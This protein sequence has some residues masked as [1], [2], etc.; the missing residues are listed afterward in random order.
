MS[1]RLCLASCFLPLDE[2][3]CRWWLR[4]R[5]ELRRHGHDLVLISAQAPALADLPVVQVPLWLHGYAAAY[6]VPE[7]PITLEEPLAQALA[8][9]DRH[10]SG[11][12]NL[13]LAPFLKGVATAQHVLRTLLNELQPALVLAWGSSLPQSVILQQLALQ[14][15][16]PCWVIERGFFPD[17]LMLEMTGHGGHSELNWSFT[18]RHATATA[19]APKVLAATR[20]SFRPVPVPA[21]DITALHK[22]YNPDGRRLL[23]ALLQHDPS[24]GLMPSDYPGARI[25]APGI[26][27]CS[28]LIRELSR[29]VAQEPDCRL[30]V[31]PH[32]QDKSDYSRWDNGRVR[33]V[34]EVS[35]AALIEAAEAVVAMTST[36]QFDALLADKPIVLAARSPLA[37]KGIAY[38]AF[39]PAEL[40]PAVRLALLRDRFD[41]RMRRAHG[42]ITRLIRDHSIG[43]SEASPAGASLRDLAV[44]LAKQSI[45]IE[46]RLTPADQLGVLRDWFALWESKDSAARPQ[47]DT[48]APAEVSDNGQTPASTSLLPGVYPLEIY[49][50][51]TKAAFD[52]I[53]A[54]RYSGAVASQQVHLPARSEPFHLPGYCVVCGGESRF[55]T[56]FLF[57]RPDAQGKLQPAWRERQIC[58]C[59]LNCR[60]RS[61]Y[62]LLVDALG[63]DRDAELYCTEQQSQLFRHIRRAF[64]RAI[65][66]EFLGD[67]VPLGSTDPQGIRNEDVTQL[68]FADAAFDAIF[69]IDV[70]EHVPDYRTG[71]AEL[72]RCLKPGGKLLLTAPFHFTKTETVIRASFGPDGSLV[73][74]LPP[75]YHGDPINPEGALC[76]NDFG[77]DLL[78]AIRAA[79][80]TDISVHVFT[81]PAYGY[82]GLQYALIGTRKVAPRAAN[83]AR[84]R[85]GS[86]ARAPRAVRSPENGNAYLRQAAE[87]LKDRQLHSASIAARHALELLPESE[88][89][90]ELLGEI[91][92]GQEQ[93]QAAGELYMK[94]SKRRPDDLETWSLRLECAK[95]AGH[96]VLADLVL[97]EALERHPE[98]APKLLAT[99]APPPAPA[100]LPAADATTPRPTPT[101][102]TAQNGHGEILGV[103]G[104]SYAN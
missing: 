16:R 70:F 93:W 104:R 57:S 81:A 99:P 15:G 101:P 48:T 64:P 84:N 1:A 26:A 97:E 43:L 44:F 100:A 60:Q 31:K 54:E 49:Q 9:R 63:L 95:K 51:R 96:E 90:H 87:L 65:G 8:V 83:A 50:V 32:P 20:A 53:W 42:F 19:P 66:S 21:A 76:F 85:S 52:E 34:R 27:S 39:S 10:W 33:I 14:Q 5:E 74:H 68:T 94:L 92:R 71:L 69:S 91:L 46:S 59:G 3:T 24:S 86:S 73:H 2:P 28:D 45:P 103:E 40:L 88:K 89:A 56:D 82:I 6:H 18:L 79:G 98:W 11:Q 4:F 12:E 47:A 72:A 102:R 13:D 22:Q 41:E 75:V 30:L 61:C 55:T 80:F 77:W 62:H 25:H 7:A 38:E 17:T 29:V 67:R 58:Q 36:T 23:V 37:A 78:D 35:T